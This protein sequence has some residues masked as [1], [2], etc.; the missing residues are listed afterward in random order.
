MPGTP[1]TTSRNALVTGLC[2][3]LLAAAIWTSYSVLARLA[4]TSGLSPSDLTLLRF[5]PGALLMAP[6]LW[7]WGLRDL[8]GIGWRR[9]VLLALLTGPVFSLLIMTGFSL[10]PLAHGAVVA[11]ACQMLTGLT[12]SAWL[13]K[14]RWTRE[15]ALGAACVTLG[16]VFM[17]GDTI[18][19]GQGRLTL[20]GDVLFAAA[21]ACWGLFGALSRRWNVDALRVTAVCVVLSFLMFA[22]AYVV[23]DDFGRLATAGT[24]MLALQIV[25]QGLGAG[26]VALLAFSRASELL[27]AGRAAF[28]GAIVPGAATL[29]AIPVLGEVPTALQVLGIVAVVLGLLLAFGAVRVL[30]LRM[31]RAAA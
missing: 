23:F 27:G 21:G 3:G 24:A 25:A 18:L 26:L 31:F 19:H 4:V 20:V 17:G 30:L 9:G 14:Q 22:P 12:L 7:R 29:L 15:T 11:P 8:A 16:L 5:A 6:L 28:F 2:W 1:E 13:A 10:A